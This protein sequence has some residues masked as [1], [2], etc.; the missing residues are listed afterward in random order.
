ML[1]TI[2][3]SLERIAFNG[4]P[5]QFMLVETTYQPFI[6][7]LTQTGVTKEKPELSGIREP[8][9]ICICCPLI[10]FLLPRHLANYASALAIELRRGS[11]PDVRDFLRFKIKNGTTGN[12][13]DI[14]VFG[15]HSDIPLTEFVYRAEVSRRIQYSALHA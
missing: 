3:S 15:H 9:C 5:L 7:L 14:N 1:H 4:D 8:S 6:S 10:S 11:P 12:F 13:E 2:L